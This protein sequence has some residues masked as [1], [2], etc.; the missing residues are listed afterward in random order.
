MSDEKKATEG[1]TR[2]GFVAIA[3]SLLAGLGLQQDAF[4]EKVRQAAAAR[5]TQPD[6]T[7][8]LIPL[9]MMEGL[10]HEEQDVLVGRVVRSVLSNE[11]AQKILQQLSQEQ[12][13]LMM[14]ESA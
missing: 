6:A 3:G 2:R 4:A 9:E 1:T 7:P 5:A 12:Y 8:P 13:E 10:T 11:E 14:K